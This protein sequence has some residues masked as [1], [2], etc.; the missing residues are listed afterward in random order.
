MES[1]IIAKFVLATPWLIYL[2]VKDYRTRKREQEERE[3]RERDRKDD[4]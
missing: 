4:E 2:G 1:M 3:A